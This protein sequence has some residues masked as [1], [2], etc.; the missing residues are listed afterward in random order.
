MASRR[1]TARDLA[2]IAIFAALIAALGLPGRLDLGGSSGVPITF[3]TL[4]VM[5]AGAVLG[6]RKGF[7]AV[8]VFEV[9]TLIG[10][11]LL[12]GGRGG[13]AV[14]ASPTGGYLVGFLL[15]VVVIGL[16]TRP[17][18]PRYPLWAGILATAVGGIVVIYAV[19]IPWTAWRTG[20]PLSTAAS[21]AAVFL[22]GDVIKAVVTALVAR[23]VHRAY[24][25]LITG[26]RATDPARRRAG[27][28]A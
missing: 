10:L 11:P 13:P 2:Q 22:P 16:L 9:L 7:L 18:L 6:A 25:G 21:G 3:Q 14:W 8:L 1:T 24:P 28:A 26:R 4:G 5:L 23:Q 20:L 12:A 17:L 19:G 27:T 15:G